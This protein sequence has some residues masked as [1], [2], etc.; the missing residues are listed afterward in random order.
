M[1]LDLA[2]YEAKA[3]SAVKK[4]WISR[5]KAAKKQKSWRQK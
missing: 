1:P 3:R 4:F 2:D 5:K